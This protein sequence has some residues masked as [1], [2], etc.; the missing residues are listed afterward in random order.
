MGTDKIGGWVKVHR[1][2]IADYGYGQK[3]LAYMAVVASADRY[4]GEITATT[5]GIARE[6]GLT[7][8]IARNITARAYRELG[9]PSPGHPRATHP[10]VNTVLE[11]GE[12]PPKG[13]HRAPTIK[14]EEEE[15]NT[16]PPE[17]GGGGDELEKPTKPKADKPYTPEF[18]RLWAA[19]PKTNGS[20]KAAFKRYCDKNLRLPRHE[21]HVDEM[22]YAIDTQI[23]Y[24]AWRDRNNEFCAEFPFLE[25]WLKEERWDN[26]PDVPLHD[27][28][29]TTPW[30]K[31][32]QEP[33]DL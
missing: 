10:P 21:Y 32:R 31:P 17:P 4:S 14:E 33:E 16:L 15:Q 9:G 20:K 5:M 19:Y 24:K 13:H 27:K 3:L 11:D 2:V 22:L 18:D 30:A 6:F 25:K 28:A 8:K 29:P 7:R 12:G 26:L 1:S 23:R